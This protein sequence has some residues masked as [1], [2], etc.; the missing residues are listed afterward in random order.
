MPGMIL[1]AK[2]I[3]MKKRQDLIFMESTVQIY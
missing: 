2:I 1:R 3:D